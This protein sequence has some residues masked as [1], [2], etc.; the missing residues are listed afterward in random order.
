MAP[1]FQTGNR[2]PSFFMNKIKRSNRTL[3]NNLWTAGGSNS[4]KAWVRA[5]CITILPTVHIFIVCYS[6]IHFNDYPIVFAP[7]GGLEPP[8]SGL[9]V[10]RNYQLCYRGKVYYTRRI[11]YPTWKLLLV[12]ALYGACQVASAYVEDLWQL[13][14]LLV[15]VLLGQQQPSLLH[16]YVPLS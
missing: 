1:S 4:D 9:T 15:L 11:I 10:Q 5:R 16:A 7:R 2:T 8:T 12:Q 3:R 14:W 13:S 6:D